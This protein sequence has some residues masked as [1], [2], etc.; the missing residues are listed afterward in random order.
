MFDDRFSEIRTRITEDEFGGFRIIIPSLRNWSTSLFLM[1]WLCG[2]AFGEV[3][4]GTQLVTWALTGVGPK[5]GIGFFLVFWVTFWTIGGFHAF[6]VLSWNLAGREVIVLGDEAITLTRQVGWL[7]RSRWLDLA[8]VRNLRYAPEMHRRSR[9]RTPIP[10]PW[11]GLGV[12]AFDHGSTTYRF[13]D[14]LSEIEARRLIA[15]IQERFKIPEDRDYQPLPVT[16]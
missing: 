7:R 10:S 1:V 6:T 12:V 13:G 9:N 4:V 3:M 15:T 5:G 11:S 8:V 16:R 2:W 14:N